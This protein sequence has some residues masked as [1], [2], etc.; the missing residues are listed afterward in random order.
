[1][2]MF[3][4]IAAALLAWGAAGAW[5]VSGRGKPNWD[6]LALRDNSA[7]SNSTAAQS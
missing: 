7:A 6:P 4:D 2:S 5:I 1:M 3:V